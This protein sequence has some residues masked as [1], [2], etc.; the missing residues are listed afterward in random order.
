MPDEPT[1]P[2]PATQPP[3]TVAL[4]LVSHSRPLAEAVATLARQM[5]GDKLTIACAAGIGPDGSELGTDGTAIA[6]AI[7][8]ADNPAGTVVLMDLGSA[9]IS[10]DVALDLIDPDIKTRVTLSAA[11]FVEGAVVAAARA[12]AGGSR[13]EVAAEATAALMPKSVQLGEESAPVQA[14]APEAGAPDAVAEATIRDPAGLHARP[15]A[16]IVALA[17]TFDASVTIADITRKSDPASAGSMVALAGLGVR[18]NDR[19]AIAARGREARQAVAAISELIGGFVGTGDAPP[20][21][22][23]ALQ[24]G[25]AIPVVPGVVMGPLVRLQ[26]ATPQVPTWRSEDPP[27]EITRLKRAVTAA[28]RSIGASAVGNTSGDIFVVQLAL[29]R[30]PAIIDRAKSLISTERH[31]AAFAWQQAI[32]EAAQH[33]RA[34][35]DPYLKAREADVRDVGL[36]VLRALLNTRPAELPSGPP[37]ILLVDELAPSE[38]ALLDPARVL[39]VIDARGG[40]TSHAAIMLRAVGIPAVAG[41]AAMVPPKG[42]QAAGLDGSTGEVWFDP[43]AEQC[44]RIAQRHAVWKSGQSRTPIGGRLK[45]PD[46][47]E[48][49]L[50]A[51]VSGLADARAARLG[52]AVGIGLLRTE[53]LFLDRAEAP[54]EAEQV[55]LLREI[56]EVFTDHP[57]V[58]RTL[59]AGGDKPIPYLAMEPEPNPFLG[60]RGI[61]LL[62]ART[63]LFETQLRAILVAGKDHDVRIMLPM[64]ATN[65]ELVRARACLDRAHRSLKQ[66]GTPHLWPVPFGIMIEVPAA[67]LVAEQLATQC[68]FFSIG[69]NDLTQYVLAAERG[70]PGLGGYAD[71][72]H[73]AVLR[74]IAEVVEAGRVAGRSVSVCGE[75]AA[76]PALAGLLVGLGVTR[77]SMG[78]ASLAGVWKALEKLPF[79]ALESAARQALTAESA[80][81]ARAA[82]ARLT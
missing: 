78:A 59:D 49:E 36:V 47:H 37:A 4:V 51:N 44:E 76:D 77:L 54:S 50:W 71:T 74:L 64:I 21:P 17:S 28:E 19:L 20:P 26:R 9:L 15:A 79:N 43:D 68:D 31:N 1:M 62:L 63:E 30:D 46:G 33:Y 69:T 14:A 75:S 52:G 7:E 22:Q 12:A 65:D 60:L 32:E 10:A 27:G 45:T 39:G 61:R 66:A 16:Q 13:A 40:P 2:T 73:P 38:A 5:A 67:A 58:V 6:A 29:L 48:V 18:T 23:R 35:E 72:A 57:I 34:L 8:Q 56:F 25:R 81:A 82:L 3:A 11:P 53:M 80:A 24:A 55:K 70:H 41:A 42:A